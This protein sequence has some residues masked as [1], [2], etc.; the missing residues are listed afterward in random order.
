VL[1]VGLTGGIGAGKSTVARMLAERGAVVVDADDLAAGALEPGTRTYERVLGLFGEEVVLT[2]GRLDRRAIA[3][4][5]FEDPE[6]RKALESIIHPEVF[7]GLAETVERYRSSDRIVVFDVPLLVE[8]GFQDAVDVVVVVTAP[9]EERIRRA[10]RGRE[11]TEADVRARIAAQA[12]PDLQ[13]A[14]A[15]VVIRNDRDLA[16]LE[17]EVADLWAD[18]RRRAEGS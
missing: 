13:Q 2:D 6:T 18:L 16:V 7:R 9:E 14:A 11:M 5:T 15:D 3:A 4:R 17:R 12:D 1:L 10:A 8:T